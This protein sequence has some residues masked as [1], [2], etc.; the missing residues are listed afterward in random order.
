MIQRIQ[1]EQDAHFFGWLVEA[2]KHAALP[3]IFLFG[4]W[5]PVLVPAQEGG[6]LF[7]NGSLRRLVMQDDV[8]QGAVHVQF[9]VVV[10]EA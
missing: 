1:T 2:S 8:Q 7:H 10:D 5:Q 3:D 6:G 4:T 9:P